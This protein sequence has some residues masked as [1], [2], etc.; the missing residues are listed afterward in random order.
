MFCVSLLRSS[1]RAV[2]LLFCYPLSTTA[3]PVLSTACRGKSLGM[4]LVKAVETNPMAF[5][6]LELKDI[7]EA[8]DYHQLPLKS[9]EKEWPQMPWAWFGW[10]VWLIF[11]F[12]SVPPYS[13]L[14]VHVCFTKA[15]PRSNTWTPT[16]KTHARSRVQADR[17]SAKIAAPGATGLSPAHSYVHSRGH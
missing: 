3:P 4:A 5:S 1:Q 14:C 10:Y 17:G 12:A 8:W 13:C 2:H 7:K 15:H 9:W 6:K 16:L 11:F